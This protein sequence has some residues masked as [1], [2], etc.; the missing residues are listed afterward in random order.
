MSRMHLMC[1]ALQHA[2]LKF[3]GA[4][5]HLLGGFLQVLCSMRIIIGTPGNEARLL[6]SMGYIK[7]TPRKTDET[8]AAPC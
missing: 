8:A 3:S 7:V 5:P 6:C 2:L 1:S 4:Q